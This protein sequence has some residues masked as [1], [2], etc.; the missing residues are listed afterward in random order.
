MKTIDTVKKLKNS[1]Q[2]SI[3]DQ[4]YEIEP[5]IW[6]KFH[7]RAGLEIEEKLWKELSNENDFLKYYK[8]GIIKLKKM[9]TKYEM[10][11]YLLSKG[12]NEAIVKQVIAKFVERKYLDDSLYAKD[13]IRM[14][15]YL[16]GPLVL[17]HEL[18]EKGVDFE[19]IK[20]YVSLIDEKE[21]LAEQIPKKLSSIKNKS[22]RQ[23]LITVKTHF[24]RKG[25]SMDI[26]SKILDQ[27]SSHYQ[28]DEMK[29][30][31]K[32]YDKLYLRLSKKLDGYEL[33]MTIKEKLYQKGYKLDDIQKVLK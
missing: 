2:I 25:Y 9:L 10:K 1:Y 11:N 3:L 27:A 17:E 15:K 28:G 24:I 13:Y 22:K 21:I 5:E 32:D 8:L 30:L 26:V 14:K 20:E 7:L 18:K 16:S 29:L 12:A 19:L 31:Q 6:I 33:S 4:I 23:A